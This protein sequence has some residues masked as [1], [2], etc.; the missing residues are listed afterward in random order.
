MRISVAICDD[1]E[2]ERLQ[3]ARLLKNYGR[4]KGVAWEIELL[5]SG[6]AFLDL[7]RPGR[8]DIILMDIYMDGPDGM[9]A[10]RRLRAQDSE[11]ALLFVTT[12]SLIHI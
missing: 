9:E 5:E 11:C 6:A 4:R 10:A 12:L 1:L 2:E 7:F 8:W 3:M